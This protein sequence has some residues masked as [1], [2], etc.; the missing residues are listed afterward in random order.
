MPR[1]DEE[2]IQAART[3]DADALSELLS[4]HGPAIER[5][6]QINDIWRGMLEPADVMQVT[7]LEA[8]LHI[9]SFDPERG[10]PFRAWLNHIAAN[11]LRDAIR[12]LERA[13]KPQPR[14]RIRPPVVDDSLVGLYE[15]LGADSLTPSRQVGRQD[16]CRMLERAIAGLP[17]RYE[18]VIRLYDL[19]GLPIEEV[20]RRVGRS[21]G[22]IHM[23]RSRAHER[24]VQELGSSSNFL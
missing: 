4:R 23:L 3:G 17:P 16:A 19:E 6:L 2:L 8:F 18:Q 24:L 22:A 7:Y 15:L 13:K 12:G 11:N 9:R 10:T 1:T 21:A 20:A 5:T 14:D